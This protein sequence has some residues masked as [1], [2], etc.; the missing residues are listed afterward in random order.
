MRGV[1]ARFDGHPAS[2][3]PRSFRF[4]DPRE[5]ISA[6]SAAEVPAL[7]ARVERWAATGLHAAGF[8]AYEAAPAFD[9]ALATHPADPRFPL[10]WF[11]AFGARESIAPPTDHAAWELLEPW[12]AALHAKEYARRVDRVRAW[13]AAGDCYQANLT[14][15]LRAPFRGEAAGFYAHL[16]STQRAG[17]CALLETPEW[18]LISA[19]PELFFRWRGNEL[20]LRPMKGTRP[21]GRWPEEDRRLAEE[22]H[23]S[24]KDRA[25]NLMIV[26]LLRNDAGRVAEWGSVRVPRLWE[27]ERYPT[28]HQ[29][30][31]TVRA[32]T[33]PG[34][35]LLDVFRALFPC[36]SV[37]GAPKVRA[38][39][40]LRDLEDEP[41]GVYTGAI[42][43]VSPGEVVFSVAIRTVVA[44]TGAECVELG[45]GSGIVWDSQPADEYAECLTKAAFAAP[46][47]HFDLLETLGWEPGKGYLLLARHLARLRWSSERW[48]FGL[49]EPR[50]RR[51]LEAAVSGVQTAPDEGRRWRVRLTVSRSGKASADADVLPAGW[52][53]PVRVAIDRRPVDSGDPRLDHKTTDRRLYDERRAAHPEADDVVLTNER[54]EVTESTV[55]NVIA[56]IGRELLTPPISAGLLPGVLRA[57][58]LEAGEVREQSLRPEDLRRA[59]AV[60]IV[61]SVR[62]WRSASVS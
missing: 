19:S 37:T 38:M 7:L 40:I 52:D 11:T 58:L 41:R 14:F 2:P 57:A 51:A 42:G 22:L 25:E 27:V 35:S 59:D 5:T 4:L 1:A 29:L 49:D 23:A 6:H 18:A 60:W 13:I 30:T 21:R 45:V 24:P 44:R 15:P 36:G 46:P 61:N 20:E 17:F 3:A 31:S 62:G 47:A 39:Q 48:G 16:C 28:V 53:A 55:G 33:R 32:R 12:R 34:T 54:G 8:V 26:D 43:F 9:P 10:A 56:G 50:V